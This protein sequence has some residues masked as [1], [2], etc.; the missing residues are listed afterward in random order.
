MTTMSADL[1]P[2]AAYVVV[3]PEAVGEVTLEDVR[4][5]SM[6]MSL[7]ALREGRDVGPLRNR[8]TLGGDV[9]FYRRTR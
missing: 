9:I 7:E 2:W 6:L 8:R 3:R 5:W 1:L 4:A